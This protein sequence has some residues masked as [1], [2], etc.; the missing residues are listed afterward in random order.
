MPRPRRNRRITCYPETTYFKPLGIPMQK[1]KQIVLSFEEF[2]ALR[3]KNFLEK[4]QKEIAE[5]MGVS[6]STVHRMLMQAYKKIAEA[7]VQ[8]KAIKIEGGNFIMEQ[9]KKSQEG[10]IA[11]SALFDS[12][13]GDVDSRFGR[14]PYFLLVTMKEG[15]AQHVEAVENI[16]KNM[17]GGVGMAVAQMLAQKNINAVITG[18]IGPRALDVLK[19]LQIPVFSYKGSVEEAIA[20]FVDNKLMQMR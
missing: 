17:Q 3:L 13:K 6:Q 9:E 4:D 10:K 2:E 20:H 14:C 1:L 11:I 5:K 18:N 16:H 7:I 15:K 12:L 19:Q 8:S